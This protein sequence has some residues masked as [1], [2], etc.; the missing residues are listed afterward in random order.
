MK[1]KYARQY[2]RSR[3]DKKLGGKKKQA[4]NSGDCWLSDGDTQEI[5]HQGV[6]N[7]SYSDWRVNVLGD[8]CKLSERALN[9]GYLFESINQK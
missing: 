5:W 6:E 4:Q 9:R 8:K 7:N 2:V 3:I 1:A